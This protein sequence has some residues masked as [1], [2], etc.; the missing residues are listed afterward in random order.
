MAPVQA[1][2]VEEAKDLN[3]FQDKSLERMMSS[4][5]C[6]VVNA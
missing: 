5:V 3:L 1:E 2:N 6:D 4:A